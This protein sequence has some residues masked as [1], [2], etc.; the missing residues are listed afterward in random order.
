M[1]LRVAPSQQ[2]GRADY[3]LQA[4]IELRSEVKLES[5]TSRFSA[6]LHSTRAVSPYFTTASLPGPAARLARARALSTAPTPALPLESALRGEA[7]FE[8]RGASLGTRAGGQTGAVRVG[9]ELVGGNALRFTLRGSV[10]AGLALLIDE[11]KLVN[12]SCELNDGPLGP[13]L[14][15]LVGLQREGALAVAASWQGGLLL[16][17]PRV[18]QQVVELKIDHANSELVSFR[19][20]NARTATSGLGSE[21][22]HP[23][24]E[25]TTI[26]R[27]HLSRPPAKF[28][29]D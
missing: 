15:Q 2:G 3:I 26:L 18:R 28:F 7:S 17:S 14:R 29:N 19:A 22:K 8:G 27:N 13:L 1:R 23:I 6:P 12:K 11:L 9:A 25:L 21:A 24:A 16:V 10:S 4:T 20:L 5:P